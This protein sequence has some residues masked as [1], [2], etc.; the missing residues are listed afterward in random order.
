MPNDIPQD[1]VALVKEYLRIVMIPDPVGARRFVDP[2]L[3]I[4]FTGARK[5][6]DPADCTAFNATRYRR[7]QKRFEHTHL[8]AGGTPEET[9]VYNTGTLHGEWLDGTP[10]EGN[11]YVD[12]Y[13]VRN[14]RIVR[15]E[16]WNDTAEHLLLRQTPKAR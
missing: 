3:E 1:P 14:G 13:T 10:F 4:V 11:R 8:V 9:V 2:S 6:S 15:L 7:V 16:V 12:R 5:M